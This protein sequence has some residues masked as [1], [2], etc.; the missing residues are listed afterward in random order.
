MKKR[1]MDTGQ[2]N[3]NVV[4]YR[5]KTVTLLNIPLADLLHGPERLGETG[6][7]SGRHTGRGGLRE[8]LRHG[9]P[10]LYGG[11]PQPDRRQGDRS[12]R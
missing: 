2:A 9:L 6:Q 11:R 8:A 7:G 10:A 3:E 1:E 4:D 5:H 12:A